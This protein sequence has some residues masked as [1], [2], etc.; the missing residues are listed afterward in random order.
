MFRLIMRGV[1]PGP[2]E[3]IRKESTRIE[4]SRE[5]EQ[6]EALDFTWSDYLAMYIAIVRTLLPFV[7]LVA[8]VYTVFVYFFINI[9]LN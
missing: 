1:M 3:I 5:H 4:A 8:V 2:E 6:H 9:W 7:L